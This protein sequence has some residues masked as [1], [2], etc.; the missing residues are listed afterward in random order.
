MAKKTIYNLTDVP[1]R[2]LEAR[3]LVDMQLAVGDILIPPG[4]FAEVEDA[5]QYKAAIPH[6]FT[7]GALHIGELPSEYVALHLEVAATKKLAPV[8][9][10]PAKVPATPAALKNETK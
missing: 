5:E 4:G 9:V 10:L 7:H 2:A 6:F 3:G 8:T 1:T